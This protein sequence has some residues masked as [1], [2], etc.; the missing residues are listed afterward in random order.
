VNRIL[1]ENYGLSKP[2]DSNATQKG[3]G[4]NRRVDFRLVEELEK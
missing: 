2:V 3:R 4:K 1:V